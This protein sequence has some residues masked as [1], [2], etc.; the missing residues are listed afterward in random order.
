[1]TSRKISAPR[2]VSAMT[3]EDYKAV[4]HM[5]KAK[6]EGYLDHVYRCGYDAG[7]KDLAKKLGHTV[8]PIPAVEQKYDKP[9][10]NTNGNEGE[11]P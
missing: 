11:Q 1:M 2:G 3:R 6:L 9:D 10:D 8:T 4:K 7:V 5:D